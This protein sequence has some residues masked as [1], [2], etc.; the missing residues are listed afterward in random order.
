MG[1]RRGGVQEVRMACMLT[2]TSDEG[3]TAVDRAQSSRQDLPCG[4]I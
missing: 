4:Q 1:A 3:W 2:R